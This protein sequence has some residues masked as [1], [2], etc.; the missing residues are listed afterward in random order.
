M[1]IR[2]RVHGQFDVNFQCYICKEVLYSRFRLG[3]HIKEC[4]KKFYGEFICKACGMKFAAQH[5]LTNHQRESHSNTANTCNIC[6]KTFSGKRYLTMHMKA[7]HESHVCKQCDKVF[8]S[9]VDMSFHASKDHGAPRTEKLFV[10]CHL[11]TDWFKNRRDLNEHIA[12]VH[13]QAKE[14][15]KFLK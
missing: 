4:H 9:S 11:C 2:D 10:D 6:N 14:S 1:C 5:Y 7:N 3:T 8:K 15:T 13:P 12:K